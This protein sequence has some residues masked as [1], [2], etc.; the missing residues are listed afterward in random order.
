MVLNATFVANR[1]RYRPDYWSETRVAVLRRVMTSKDPDMLVFDKSDP[2]QHVEKML[3]GFGKDT[4]SH[5]SK[6]HVY[7]KK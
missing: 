3:V 1:A 6:E 4:G 2:V 5:G 7:L